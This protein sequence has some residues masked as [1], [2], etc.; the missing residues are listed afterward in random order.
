MWR[1]LY[2]DEP[3]APITPKPLGIRDSRHGGNSAQDGIVRVA[4]VR[5]SIQS[6]LIDGISGALRNSRITRS[7]LAMKGLPKATRSTRPSAMALLART[8]SKTVVGR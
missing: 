1:Y 8:L 4:L 2:L 6:F 7:G 5:A 3:G